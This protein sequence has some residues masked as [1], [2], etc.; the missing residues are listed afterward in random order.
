[1]V[2]HELVDEINTHL[3][4][5]DVTGATVS[6]LRAVVTRLRQSRGLSTGTSRPEYKGLSRM[7][8]PELQV[9]CRN[10][11]VDPR[12]MT[13][14]E[15]RAFLTGWSV[16][17]A[18]RTGRVAG[19][20][21]GEP[22]GSDEIDFGRH[23]GLMY[24]EVY[25]S[26]PKYCNWVLEQIHSGEETSPQLARLGAWIDKMNRLTNPTEQDAEMGMPD[27]GPEEEP[28]V[29][30]RARTPQEDYFHMDSPDQE[31]EDSDGETEH[32]PNVI[33]RLLREWDVLHNKPEAA[34][35]SGSGWTSVKPP[36]PKWDPK[37]RAKPPSMPGS[38]AAAA[39][40]FVRGAWS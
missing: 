17:E 35:S 40:R 7:K 36:S 23:K 11:G 2:K 5:L 20:P 29:P 12:G 15:M 21:L 27:S 30:L 10:S 38:R 31:P 13:N 19:Y 25:E 9:L 34:S 3:E 1:M 16:E 18:L 22:H 37:A 6:Q 33:Q 24:R 28:A 39:A 4:G 8:K 26:F 14:D 32:P